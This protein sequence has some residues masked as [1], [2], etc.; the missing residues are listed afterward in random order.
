M[1]K[2]YF[3]YRDLCSINNITLLLPTF[4][5]QL[6]MMFIATLRFFSFGNKYYVYQQSKY[7]LAKMLRWTVI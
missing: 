3:I 1:R 6:G 7:T 5:E 2:H 4:Q